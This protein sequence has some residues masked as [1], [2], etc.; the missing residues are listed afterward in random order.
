MAITITWTPTGQPTTT[1]TIN[2]AAHASLDAYRQSLPSQPADVLTLVLNTIT[3][4]LLVPAFNAKPPADVQVA[5]QAAA[6]SQAAAVAA[7]QT[8][9][10]SAITTTGGQ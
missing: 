4:T 2:D 3:P 9:I 7:L 8:F 1:L 10:A 5:Q 6:T